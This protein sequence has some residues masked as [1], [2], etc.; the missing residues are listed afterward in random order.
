MCRSPRGISAGGETEEEG[1]KEG[2]AEEKRIDDQRHLADGRHQRHQPHAEDN[3]EK[4]PDPGH[5]SRLQHELADDVAATGADGAT[6]AD[7]QPPGAH[8][9]HHDGENPQTA[10]GEGDAGTDPAEGLHQ[11][12]SLFLHLH[13]VARGHDREV[14]LLAGIEMMALAQNGAGRRLGR[15]FLTAAGELDVD[16]ADPALVGEAAQVGGEGNQ[17]LIVLVGADDVGPL[18]SKDADDPGA[19]AEEED[20]LAEGGCAGAEEALGDLGAEDTDLFR[21]GFV[22]GEEKAPDLG[23]EVA[24]RRIA[25]PDPE[26]LALHLGPAAAHRHGATGKGGAETRRRQLGHEDF[27]VGDGEGCRLAPHPRGAADGA[28]TDLAA[29][30]HEEVGPELGRLDFRLGIHRLANML[31]RRQRQG[32]KEN[33]GHGEDG[34]QTVAAQGGEGD[35]EG[36]EHGVEVS[37]EWHLV[38]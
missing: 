22:G 25:R 8:Q 24:H 11:L 9:Q 4:A 17:N 19:G 23:F 27:G 33:P 21:I 36:E 2:A 16:A 37:V 10:D 5:D 30:G 6:D 14:V 20:L 31:H 26:D 32:A 18:G 28:E 29:A 12:Q 7:L 3:A 38:Q 35:F 34:A 13:G 15:R 1:A